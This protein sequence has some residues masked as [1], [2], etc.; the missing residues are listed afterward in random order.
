ML[1]TT[2]EWRGLELGPATAYQT[3]RIDGWEDLPPLDSGDGPRPGRH[4]DRPGVPYARARTITVTG[5]IRTSRDAVA[6]RLR[7]LRQACAVPDDETLH[8]L[9]IT[10]LGE[11]LSVD[12]RVSQRIISVDKHARLGH[13]PYVLQWTCPDPIRYDPDPVHVVVPAGQERYLPQNGSTSSR[14][15]LTFYGPAQAPLELTLTTPTGRVFT[16]AWT[17]RLSTNVLAEWDV[18][19]VN[20]STGVTTG[21]LVNLAGLPPEAFAIP[22]GV[23]TVALSAPGAGPNTRVHISYRHAYL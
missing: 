4:G 22:P 11:T 7:Q 3:V 13:I 8:P 20:C 6:D 5:R 1:P 15:T 10:A 21:A 18:L 12:A 14:P 17:G 19:V 2:L 16:L 9:T 23:S